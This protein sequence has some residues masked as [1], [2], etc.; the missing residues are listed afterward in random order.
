MT[1]GAAHTSS[2]VRVHGAKGLLSP[3]SA[4]Q[5][6][7]L[8]QTRSV[9]TVHS[10][11]RY[12]P[13][14]H[15][16][17]VPSP[18]RRHR[19][20]DVHV[21]AAASVWCTSHGVHG[22][23]ASRVC[24]TS[25]TKVPWPHVRH[26]RSDDTVGP[27]TTYCPALQLDTGW[28]DAASA[29]ADHVIPGS[30]ST[31]RAS[32]AAAQTRSVVG[33]GG[34][35]CTSPTPHAVMLAH[36]RSDVGV[37]A[38]VVNASPSVQVDSGRHSRSEV[39]VHGVASYWT[40]PHCAVHWVHTVLVYGLHRAAAYCSR[41]HCVQGLHT[42]SDVAVG[43]AKI[44]PHDGHGSGRKAAHW[45]SPAA[46]QLVRMYCS[47]LP[48]VKGTAAES[49]GNGHPAEQLV[50]S[51][52]PT[53][54][55]VPSGHAAHRPLLSYS[56]AEQATGGRVGA[57][58]GCNVGGRVGVAVG[59]TGA[60]VGAVVGAVGVT[61]G[62][63]VDGWLVGAVGCSVGGRVGDAVPSVGAVVTGAAVGAAVVGAWV[64][65]SVGD[66]VGASLGLVVGGTVG[67][68]VGTPVVGAGVGQVPQPDSVARIRR[69]EHS[70][71]GWHRPLAG[72]PGV[73]HWAPPKAAV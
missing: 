16:G 29:A 67:A 66:D 12:C 22:V 19:R 28:H 64:G 30:H 42:V 39:G 54:E 52:A 47:P 18:Q 70:P 9:V 59:E 11:A 6:E 4:E 57:R 35:T 69:G 53:P 21:P 15:R 32:D 25:E 56:P 27:A 1:A 31:D 65:R 34:R 10:A 61:V 17:P 33:V 63:R 3:L 26:R 13:L 72:G 8:A 46:V 58:V 37:A 55:K 36:R 40:A 24:C 71:Q 62:A 14:G 50:H 41:G 45:R 2:W 5:P 60:A 43:S 73:L 68:D 48:Y 51:V 44:H 38:A 20:S 7:Q 49:H 23:H